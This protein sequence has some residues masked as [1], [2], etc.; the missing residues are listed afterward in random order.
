MMARTIRYLRQHAIAFVA[1]FLALGGTAG[2]VATSSSSYRACVERGT[3][4]L[5]LAAPGSRDGCPRGERQIRWSEQGPRGRKGATGAQGPRGLEGST[6][7]QGS[8]GPRGTQGPQGVPGPQ[9][10]PGPATGSAGGDLTGNYPNPTIA[11]GKVTTPDFAPGAQA[12]DAAKLG[13]TPASSYPQG[14]AY[15][16]M[17]VSTGF[18]PYQFAAVSGV[19]AINVSCSPTEVAS[20]SYTNTTSSVTQDVGINK[21]GSVTHD[22]VLPPGST[23]SAVDVAASTDAHLTYIVSARG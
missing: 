10:P 20:Y 2:A 23:T 3:G 13:G 4:E 7:P 19:G 22:F 17:G 11:N 5:Q 15:G 12:P 21:G 9:G 14:Q 1:L 6:G 8:T 18:G 16:L